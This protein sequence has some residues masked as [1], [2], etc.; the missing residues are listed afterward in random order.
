MKLKLTIGHI[1]MKY[2]EDEILD[3]TQ[4]AGLN[5]EVVGEDAIAQIAEV[6]IHELKVHD[7][8]SLCLKVPGFRGVKG[9]SAREIIAIFINEILKKRGK[10]FLSA[11]FEFCTSFI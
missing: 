2:R 9:K 7:P 1:N 11:P 8:R 6:L 5:T 3:E 4:E 10:L